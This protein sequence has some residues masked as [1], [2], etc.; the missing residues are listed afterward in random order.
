MGMLIQSP[1]TC[2]D[3]SLPKMNPLWTPEMLTSRLALRL[4]ADAGKTVD[5]T[6]ELTAWSDTTRSHSL[7]LAAGGGAMVTYDFN[8]IT[9]PR[10]T[11]DGY[12]KTGVIS[13][14]GYCGFFLVFDL[15]DAS[16][17]QQ[18]LFHT[19]N[20]FAYRMPSGAIAVGGIISS[21][22]DFGTV[23][24]GKHILLCYTSDGSTYKLLDNGA[25]SG[26][27]VSGAV[28]T[29]ITNCRLG[30]YDPGLIDAGVAEFWMTSGIIS[31]A[32]AAKIVGYA[33]H[34]YGMTGLLPS[35]HPYKT[36]VPRKLS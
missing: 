33:A 36:V 35:D 15:I 18:M 13:G 10:F 8:G 23:G 3:R 25:Q 16:A 1:G 27:T 29:A 21:M 32:D 2:T 17:T 6:G 19:D 28:T 34:H 14:A 22:F 4:T 26:T 30:Q 7:A 24:A 20:F 9:V 12:A 11:L 5:G 31:D